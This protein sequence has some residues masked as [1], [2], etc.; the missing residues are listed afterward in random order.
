MHRKT[1]LT[2]TALVGGL[3]SASLGQAQILGGGVVGNVTGGLAGPVTGEV[4][5][6]VDTRIAA[7]LPRVRAP[8]V[9]VPRIEAPVRVD[10]RR[11]RAVV[12]AGVAPIPVSQTNVYMDRQ[13]EVLQGELAGTGVNLRREGQ[14]IV[15]EMPGD[16]TFAFNKTDIRPRFVPVLNTVVRVLNDYPATFVDISGHT[17]S[18]GS[19]AYNLALSE[20][21]ADT[22]ASYLARGQA[23]P[24]RMNVIGEG[25]REPIASNATIQGRAANRRVEIVL[26][27]VEG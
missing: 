18:I 8:R 10:V 24:V 14:A 20:R 9:R 23:M 22:V 13:Y 26:R 21:R 19:D 16:V 27:A 5:A 25:E 7:P 6:T 3:L 2:T 4:S 15:L 12:A 1:I 17:D 11:Q